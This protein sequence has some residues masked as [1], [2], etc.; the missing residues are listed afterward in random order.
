[1]NQSVVDRKSEQ[2]AMDAIVSRLHQ[3]AWYWL[4]A[5]LFTCFYVGTSLYISAHRLLWYDEIYT[6]TVCRLPS[7]RTI[8]QALCEGFEQVPAL[9]FLIER[10]FDQLFHH[11]DI[12]IRIPSV[13]AFGAGVLVTFDI[14]RRLTDG[15]YGLIA[16]TFLTTSFATYYAYEA[17]P[18]AICFMLAA[19]ALWLWVA[20]KDESKGAALAFGALFMLGGAIHYYFLLTAVPFGMWAL[21][22]RRIF[23]PKPIAAAVGSICALAALYPQ[24]ASSLIRVRVGSVAS[25]APPTFGSLQ[26]IYLEF[27]P[28][29]SLPLVAVVIGALVFGKSRRR[30]VAPMTSGERIGWLFLTV[31][32]AAFIIARMVTH[33]F[34]NRYLIAF[35]P[36]IA[37]AMTCLVWRHYRESGHLSLAMLVVFGGFSINQ[38][39]R[40]LRSIDHIEAFGDHQQRT[41]VMVALED[42]LRRDG[43]QHFVFVFNLPFLEAWYYSKHPEQYEFVTDQPHDVS[44]KY[45]AL[46]FVSRQEL[47]TNAKQTALIGAPE[48]D[49]VQTLRQ[50]GLGLSL[51]SK[52]PEYYYLE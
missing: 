12:G 8:W 41:R 4:F 13:L 11:T 44:D 36:G 39:R 2:S 23:H 47:I 25:W 10:V 20:T 27:F 9:Y 42:T 18:Y 51:R 43:K 49:L 28:A 17:R 30:L 37:V 40:T 19:I 52:Y 5:V 7:V 1:M 24:I 34:Y 35:I 21:A 48:D 26:S 22:E 3:P 16:I 50:A 38:Q 31:P 46:K 29:A 15:L 6:A 45:I 33:F 32:L 14:A